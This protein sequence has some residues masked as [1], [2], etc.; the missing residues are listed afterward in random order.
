MNLINATRRTLQKVRRDSRPVGS[1]E[2]DLWR[3]TDARQMRVALKAAERFDL[4]RKHKGRRNGPLGYTGLLVFRALWRFVRFRDGCLCPSYPRLMRATGLSKGAVAGALK[5]LAA[6]GFLTW[7]RRLEYTGEVGVRGREVRQ[8]TNAYALAVP[9][10]ALDL[11]AK[12]AAPLP[13]DAVD[14]LRARAAFVRDCEAQAFDFSPLGQA[15][16][17]LGRAVLPKP[18]L[19]NAGNPSLGTFS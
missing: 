9:A 12:M 4:A 5:R 10:A 14:R 8:A 2:A 11:V 19:L 7:R 13:L 6:A 16:A 18:S 17:A 3:P 1:C 15:V